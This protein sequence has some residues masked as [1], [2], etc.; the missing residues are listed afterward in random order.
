MEY[1]LAMR[2]SDIWPFVATWTELESVMLSEISHTEKDRYH[3][4]SLFFLF[5]F[6][7]FVYFWDRERQSMNGGGSEREEDT[8]SET[9]SRLWAVGT[10]PDVWLEPKDR[11][12]MTWAKVGRLTDQAT[13]ASLACSQ[14]L[15]VSYA[16][17]LSHSNLF[18][19]PS[20]PPWVSVKFLRIHISV[21]TYGVCLSLYGLFHLA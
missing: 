4:V 5:F 17:A 9:G 10:E 1:Y 3:M 6:L 21:K 11:E 14:F 18:F 8:E 7:T 2:K 13:Q 19:F 16:L 20:P 12:I 15:R